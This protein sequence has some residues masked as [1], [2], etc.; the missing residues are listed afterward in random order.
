M[1]KIFSFLVMMVLCV[2]LLF[3]V[4]WAE[5]TKV[6]VTFKI[7]DAN[8]TVNGKTVKSEKP[9]EVRTVIFVPINIISEALGAEL[10][11]NK[12]DKSSTVK[13]N[14]LELK[15][16]V[17][18]KEATVD[19]KK[20]TLKEAPVIRNLVTMVPI[21]FMADNL[22]AEITTDEKIGKITFSKEIANPNSIKDY[23]MILK[24]TRKTMV[25]DSYYNWSMSL[26]K[27]LK[28]ENRNFN[29]T[30]TGFTADDQSYM[31]DISIRDK[32]E[33]EDL[34]T[35]MEKELE[36]TKDYT[37]LDYGKHE[38]NG[39]E[40]LTF[41]YKDDKWVY[42]DRFF[43]KDEKVFVLEL[44]I[45]DPG[46]Y[47]EKAGYMAVVNSFKLSY[48]KNGKIEDL[49][50][51]TGDGYRL[52]EN[53]KLKWSAKIL[54]EW[55][56]VKEKNKENVVSFKNGEKAEVYIS[57]YSIEKGLTLEKWV[58]DEVKKI[59]EEYNSKF[60]SVTKIEDG[61]IGD[62]KCK[63]VYTT[64]KYLGEEQYFCNIYMLGDKYR[65]IYGYV[66]DSDTYNDSKEKSKVDTMMDSF[67]F[68]QPN[69]KDV[70]QLIDPNKISITESY[71]KLKSKEYKWYVEIP[72]S[73][74]STDEE[75]ASEELLWYNSSDNN[76]FFQ[77]IVLDNADVRE[78]I[79]YFEE[80]QRKEYK[81]LEI[82]KSET[83][84]EKGTV[85]EKR[86]YSLS[87]G[88]SMNKQILYVL[89]KNGKVYVVAAGIAEIK[90]TEKNNKIIDTIWQSMK[91]E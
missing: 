1:K 18:K 68:A 46:S 47:S 84:M 80:Y 45:A 61:V 40:Y 43:I 73:W 59:N 15:V 50:D 82:V 49:S 83:L 58:E 78:F 27:T 79:S 44:Y 26:P 20:V 42:E 38:S 17:G 75:K 28:I 29:G 39:Q 62:Y 60:V 70:G 53:K 48:V 71:K 30:N 90:D 77:L 51:V 54:P 86:V 76:M 63:K 14:G 19:G 69:F 9:Y 67:K 16:F 36:F 10:T 3:N 41:T 24:K 22:G 25:G 81:S 13:Y 21:E 57:M 91:F 85:V 32:N 6:E 52:Y 66:M 31:I 34:D 33:D 7:G 55:E 12:T 23:S 64:M 11:T 88:K 37:I 72:N 8:Y 87:D 74:S 35:I 4:A 5:A 2:G 89:S 65:Y 56:E